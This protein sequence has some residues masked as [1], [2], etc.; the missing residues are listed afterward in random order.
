M[1]MVLYLHYLF[2]SYKMI[3]QKF[4]IDVNILNWSVQ[5]MKRTTIQ[6]RSLPQIFSNVIT[7]KSNSWNCEIL[8][9]VDRIHFVWNS[10]EIHINNVTLPRKV[11]TTI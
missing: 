10:V 3:G 4:D 8:K 9:H 5:S 7:N 11:F 1:F 2:I 6:S